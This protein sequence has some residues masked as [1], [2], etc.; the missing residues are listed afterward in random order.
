MPTTLGIIGGGQLGMMLAQSAEPLGI[1]C[2]ALDPNPDCPASGACEVIS[3]AFDD[4]DALDELASRS[5]VVTYEFENVPVDSAR[6]IATRVAVR[7]DPVALETAQDRLAERSMFERLGIDAPP[8]ARV[9]TKDDL[10]GAIERVGTPAILKARRLG[11][12][13]KGQA[14]ISDPDGAANAWDAIGAAPAILDAFVPFS[15]ELS[16]LACRS[17]AG[18]TVFY[19]IAHNVHRGGIL[20]VTRAP[21]PD[22]PEHLERAARDAASKILDEL[23]YVGVLAVEFFQIGAGDDARLLANEIAPRV[24]NSGHWTIEGAHTSQFENHIRAV[25]GLELGDPSPKGY[26]AMVNII[27][28]RPRRGAIESL[29]GAHAHMYNKQPRPGRKLGHVTITADTPALVEARLEQCTR[30]VG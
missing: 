15:R 1:A 28:A 2:V 25:V 29:A 30:V 17:T 23:N 26:S 10:P 22:V 24:H 20:R 4:D 16:V 18:R 3:G 11:Y 13:G 14:L 6:R 7:P 5:G 19:P 27:G 12:D 9:D 8:R 21:A